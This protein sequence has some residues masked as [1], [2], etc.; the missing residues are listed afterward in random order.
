MLRGG[1]MVPAWSYPAPGP[2]GRTTALPLRLRIP[3]FSLS[4]AWVTPG[5]TA[6]T[7]PS[8]RTKELQPGSRSL[9]Q[10]GVL[11]QG[12]LCCGSLRVSSFLPLSSVLPPSLPLLPL[13]PPPPSR[14]PSRCSEPL[15]LPLLQ[16]SVQTWQ[17]CC[18]DST[19]FI[20]V[21]RSTL[22]VHLGTARKTQY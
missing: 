4:L 10:V 12:V 16:R 17:R 7:S 8:V 13:I 18:N 14:G 9:L 19:S 3:P 21:I 15:L 1:R 22:T 6:E 20:N 2:A 5:E 11:S